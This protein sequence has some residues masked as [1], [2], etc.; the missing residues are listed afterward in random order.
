V[1][2]QVPPDV[3]RMIRALPAVIDVWGIRL[4]TDR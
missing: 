1:D 4:D 2:E 3:E